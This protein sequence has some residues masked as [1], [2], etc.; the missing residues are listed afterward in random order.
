MAA[1]QFFQSWLSTI[2]AMVLRAQL[3]D[4]PSDVEFSDDMELFANIQIGSGSQ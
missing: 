3:F 1:P 2:T 4:D